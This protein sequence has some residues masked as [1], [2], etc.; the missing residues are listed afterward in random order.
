MELIFYSRVCNIGD[1]VSSMRDADGNDTDWVFVNQV[2]QDGDI[3]GGQV[4][5]HVD[6]VLKQPQV[7]AGRIKVLDFPQVTIAD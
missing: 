7:D 4:P 3:M 1:I 2:K 6:I 5:D